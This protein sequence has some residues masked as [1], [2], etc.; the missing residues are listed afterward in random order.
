MLHVLMTLLIAG[1][2]SAEERAALSASGALS[3]VPF[4]NSQR[5][6]YTPEELKPPYRTVW[7]HD[8]RHKPRPAW[9]EPVWEPQRIDFDYAYAVSARGDTV[10][11]ASS[12]DHA[13]HALDL[14]SGEKKWVFFTD[15]PVRLAPEFYTEHVLFTSD[16]GFLYC[17]NQNDGSLVWKYRPEGIPDERL[18]GNEQMISRWAARSGVLVEGDRLYT[19]F[20][21][22][23]SEGVAVCCL[24]AATG[25]PI[26]I[27]DTCGHHFMARPHGTAMGGVSPQGYLAATDKLL[28]V[29]C[30][31]STPA[32]F[33]KATGRLLYHEADGDFTGGGLVM[34]AG[35]LIF[36]QADTLKKEYGA[37]LRRDD[38]AAEAEVFELATLVALDGATGREVFSLQGG[39]RGTL[40]DDGL[41]TL[42]GRKQLI[43][44][45]LKDVRRAVPGEATVIQHTLGH[46]VESEKICRWSTPVD[47]V[48]SLL[49]AGGTIIAGGRG[50]VECFDAVDGRSLWR[51]EVDGQVRAMCVT[52]GRLV[53]STTE[54]TITCFAPADA[55]STAVETRVRP[56]PSEPLPPPARGGYCLVIGQYELKALT[57]LA[58][59]FDLVI[60][61][62]ASGEPALLRSHLAD[63]GLQGTR[64]VVHRID[65][66]MLPYTDYFANEV[67][68]HVASE[69]QLAGIAPSELYRVLRPCGGV[70]AVTCPKHLAA[71]VRAEL[72]TARVPE[73]E[74]L[75]T[76]DGLRVTRGILPGA[77]QWTHQYGDAGKRVASD[78]VR[79]RLPL[80]AAWFGGLGPATILSRH[81]R[82]P[83][84]L[85][86]NGR[87]FVSGLDHLTAMDIY[88]GRILWQRSLPDFAHWPAAYRGP[89]IAVDD[90]TVYVLQDGRCLAL[91]P[92][93]G[94]T[95]ASFAAPRQSLDSSGDE[96]IWEYVAVTD[97]LLIGTLGEPNLQ[98]SWWSRAYPV[99]QTVFALEKRT[100]H[101][102]WVHWATDGID[103]NAIAI[104]DGCIC[105]IDGRPRY[106]FLARR[107]ST[108][109]EEDQSPR[110]L[111]ALEVD[112][113][114]VRWQ[115]SNI[116]PAQ[117]SLWIDD[118]VVVATPNPVGKN[119]T[120]PGVIKAG[121]GITA[122]STEDGSRLWHADQADTVQPMIIGGV[123][124]SPDAYD[125]QT[126]RPLTWPESSKRMTL[127]AGTG[128]STYSGC[129]TLAM[130]RFSSLGFKDLA[131][132]F[133]S[134]TYPL[135]RS[136][137]WI[138]MI[139]AGGLV[140]VPEGSSSCQCAYNYKTSLALMSDDRQFH[141]GLGGDDRAGS[142]GLRINFGA[143]GDRTDAQGQVWY[144][145]PRPVAYGR[146]LGSQPYGPKQAGPNLPIEEL[147]SKTTVQTWG[148]NPDWVKLTDSR[149]PWLDA[150]G[151]EGDLRWSIRP[152]Q[153]LQ[154]ADRWRVVLHFCEI[155]E[156][157]R[158]R[159]FDVK[160]QGRTVLPSLNVAATSGAVRRPVTQAFS[161]DNDKTVTLELS[162]VVPTSPPPIISGLEIV[163]E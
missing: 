113:G 70:L 67:R 81:F 27:N 130:S 80:K 86:A 128:C 57:D 116:A 31:R 161:L 66:T 84:P 143:P 146:C 13:L 69:Q 91:D 142:P 133:G 134:F 93:T 85:V 97:E 115:H 75:T 56:R 5:T 6:G 139:P 11:Y 60:F 37:D 126:G 110:K 88:N 3:G 24:D 105:L 90:A 138:N 77:G 64:V 49:H 74:I 72:A 73:E 51:G 52:A 16:D 106:D 7:V 39:S 61:A 94:E 127:R 107:G 9:Q 148:R 20:G 140:V 129:P 102:R 21:M 157:G 154:H 63:A 103:S 22:L 121:G 82:T 36:T 135:V 145:Y 104:D 122:Y 76:V 19:S 125:L 155:S 40:S 68:L 83:A 29:T 58:R 95:R 28:I 14:A 71:E 144:A 109:E 137:C 156:A 124:Y 8:A 65:G 53:V 2:V 96:T 98:R 150:C 149:M 112:T 38:E 44:V 17:L 153:E 50:L 163:F 152:P 136:S 25:E 117:N 23:A 162:R 160:L 43:A 26:W 4:C 1:G 151:L 132:G 48:Y 42:I 118:G 62:T 18:I 34:T 119:M 30:G 87:C 10:Y 114:R 111:I 99:N 47:R 100:G 159:V 54:G 46:F 101:L 78:E 59:L 92:A 41:L 158:D 35:D 123:F 12:A 15:A 141:Y 131:G 120:D 32:L 79:V 55:E 33:D 45:D 147:S 108:Q 89:G